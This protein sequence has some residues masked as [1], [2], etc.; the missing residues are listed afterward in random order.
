MTYK[1]VL[2]IALPLLAAMLV[3]GCGSSEQT[4]NLTVDQRFARAKA[5]F[6][7]EDY[8]EAINEFTVITLQFQGSQY[9]SKAQ[10]HLGECR[11]NRGEYLLAAFEYG[12][13]KRSY[14]ASPLLPDAQYKLAMSY[15][16]MSPRSSLDQQYTKKAIDEFQSFVEYFPSHALAPDADAKIRELNTKLAKK[17]Y[18][19]AKQYLVLERY[20]AAMQY[21]DDVIEKYHDTEYAPL[22]YLDKTETLIDRKK[23]SN[24]AFELGRFMSRYPNS[25][26]RGRADALKERLDNEQRKAPVPAKTQ[27]NPLTSESRTPGAR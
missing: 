4:T 13:L 21:F 15:F 11:F 9:A 20:K 23:F 5:L 1:A 24:A 26:L 19:A 12:L 8:L 22:S 14:P 16:M 7:K 10:F 3:A 6:D 17:L 18:D 27:A 25:V 2:L